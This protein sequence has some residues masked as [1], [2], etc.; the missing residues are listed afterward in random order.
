MFGINSNATYYI[1]IIFIC[2]GGI[3]QVCRAYRTQSQIDNDLEGNQHTL[4]PQITYTFSIY[5]YIIFL[6]FIVRL[7]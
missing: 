3:F 1:C 4:T 5:I 2:R 6:K 7:N